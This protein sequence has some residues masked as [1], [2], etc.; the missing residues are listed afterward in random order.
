MLRNRYGGTGGVG[1]RPG[2]VMEIMQNDHSIPI[3]Y[4]KAWK[5]REIAIDRGSGNA[6]T[7][8]LALPTYLAKLSNANPGSVMAIETTEAAEG[9]HRFKYLFLAFGASVKGFTYMRK[10]VI[11]D[12]THLKGKYSG[13]LLTASAQDGNSQIF[14]IGFGTVDS[15]NDQA[16]TWFFTKLLDVVP[17]SSDLVFIINVFIITPLSCCKILGVMK[18]II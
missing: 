9:S 13:C 1:P 6:D 12:G 2:T 16:W 7:S 3:I 11:I 5:S 17:D 4:W 14:P 18:N 15:E 8:Y 10:M